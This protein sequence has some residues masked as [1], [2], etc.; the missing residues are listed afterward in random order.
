MQQQ[1]PV[2]KDAAVPEMPAKLPLAAGT[3]SAA[4]TAGSAGVAPGLP[5]RL[6]QA[7]QARARALRMLARAE[8]NAPLALQAHQQL[9][10]AH[11]REAEEKLLIAEEAKRKARAS[12]FCA[13][14]ASHLC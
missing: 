1:P 11:R 12:S 9:A 8:I 4:P 7:M 2:V 13:G 5:A 14:T 3:A 10:E 6:Q